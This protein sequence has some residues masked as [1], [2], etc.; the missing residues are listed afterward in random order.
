MVGITLYN[1]K[2]EDIKHRYWP[3]LQTAEDSGLGVFG[4]KHSKHDDICRAVT[5]TIFGLDKF[6][7]WKGNTL[8]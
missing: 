6:Q 2:W 3:H 5:M 1:R 8:E 4:T 7:L